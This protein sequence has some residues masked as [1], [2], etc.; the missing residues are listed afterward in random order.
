MEAPFWGKLPPLINKLFSEARVEPSALASY[1]DNE[2]ANDPVGSSA[3]T[4]RR[5]S[6]SSLALASSLDDWGPASVKP[7]TPDLFETF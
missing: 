4:L 7:P 2:F 1:W 5:A 6:E 3:W